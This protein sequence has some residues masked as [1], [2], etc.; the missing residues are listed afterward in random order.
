MVRIHRHLTPWRR[1]A[2]RLDPSL[3]AFEL[4]PVLEV[5]GEVSAE[6]RAFDVNLRPHGVQAQ[7]VGDVDVDVLDA[8]PRIAALGA[9]SVVGVH[10]HRCAPASAQR[11]DEVDHHALAT[12]VDERRCPLGNRYLHRRL[13]LALTA[14]N[15]PVLEVTTVAKHSM[16]VLEL[17]R[18]QVLGA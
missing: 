11:R 2:A 4:G 7:P 1:H 12:L 5:D 16:N 9:P 18:K 8:A 14:D 15:T 17:P 13:R 6:D 3:G 10:G